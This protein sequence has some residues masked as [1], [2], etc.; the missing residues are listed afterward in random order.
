[1]QDGGGGIIR[2]IVQAQSVIPAKCGGA[3]WRIQGVRE[4]MR[5]CFPHLLYRRHALI[6]GIISTVKRK[7]SAPA[8]GRSLQ[9]QHL[10]ALLPRVAYLL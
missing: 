2:H 10:Q 8:P 7:L 1:M 5:Q 6:E 9:T 3:Y 4:Q